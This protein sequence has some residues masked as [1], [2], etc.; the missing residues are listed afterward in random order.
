MLKK[1]EVGTEWALT[2]YDSENFEQSRAGGL[3]DRIDLLRQ[4]MAPQSLKRCIS[5][6]EKIV[7]RSVREAI[8]P[9]VSPS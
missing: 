8:L 9:K 2:E 5:V 1:P 6:A 4:R 7:V 3:S